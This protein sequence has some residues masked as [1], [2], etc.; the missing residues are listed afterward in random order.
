MVTGSYAVSNPCPCGRLGSRTRQ[1]RCTPAEIRKEQAA[2]AVQ[3]RKLN[4]KN[5]E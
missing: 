1:C 4:R 5:R 3:Y 2:E